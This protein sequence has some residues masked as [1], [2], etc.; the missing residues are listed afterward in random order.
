MT[1]SFV[2]SKIDE[3]H[4]D[5]KKYSTVRFHSGKIGHSVEHAKTMFADHNSKLI[6]CSMAYMHYLDGK[7]L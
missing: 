2:K 6:L 3:V 1:S 7:I 5:V 4:V